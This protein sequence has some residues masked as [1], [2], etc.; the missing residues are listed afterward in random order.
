VTPL[1]P[2]LLDPPDRPALRAGNHALT[3]A[4]LA[5]VATALAARIA[6]AR[7]VAVHAVPGLHTAVA[8]AAAVLAGVPAVPLNPRLGERELGHVLADA[9]PDVVLAAPG[10]RVAAELPR[11]DVDLA[12]RG[13]AV[14]PDPGPVVPEV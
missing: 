12:A 10:A 11:V 4:E 13:G 8:V 7:R 2:T 3:H 1:L 6:G 14:A 5:S 9:A